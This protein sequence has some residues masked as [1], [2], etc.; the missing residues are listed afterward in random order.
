MRTLTEK[1]KELV[2][3]VQNMPERFKASEKTMLEAVRC[4]FKHEEIVRDYI[5]EHVKERM[6]EGEENPTRLFEYEV[7]QTFMNFMGMVMNHIQKGITPSN[8]KVMYCQ[9]NGKEFL[10]NLVEFYF[11]P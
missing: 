2:E 4:F 7:N 10:E 8:L 6:E 11:K 1:E 9:M 5:Y 3:A